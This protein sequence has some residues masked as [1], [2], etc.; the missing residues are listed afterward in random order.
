M[1][2]KFSNEEIYQYINNYKEIFNKEEDVFLPAKISYLI[3]YN[4]QQFEKRYNLIEKER[5]N[6]GKKYGKLD[7]SGNYNILPENMEKAQKELDQLAEIEDMID[8]HY[9][10][11]SELEKENMNLSLK[12]I[13]FLMFMIDQDVE[14]DEPF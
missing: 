10:P 2:K 1:K 12:Q 4:M 7:E 9:I 14:L 5:M 3:Q 13:R 6:I 11:L 8:I